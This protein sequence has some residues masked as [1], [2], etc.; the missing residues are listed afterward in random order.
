MNKKYLGIIGATGQVGVGAVKTLLNNYSASLLLGGRKIA[1][2]MEQFGEESETMKYQAV[3]VFNEASIQAFCENCYL[4]IN[5]AGPS[6]LIL[7]R[8]AEACLVTNTTYID[9]SGDKAMKLAI[10]DALAKH[11]N[12]ITCAISGGVYP[13]LTEMFVAYLLRQKWVE[14][15]SCYFAGKGSF[16][17]TGA[18]D[19]ISSLEK[20]EGYGMSYYRN[21]DIKKLT[22]GIGSQK[23][24][25]APFHQVYT[26]PLMNEEFIACIKEYRAANAF[27]YNTFATSKILSDFIMIK[28]M[29][30][31]KTEEE[32]RASAHRLIETYHTQD[33]EHEGFI[34]YVETEENG[35]TQTS[36][37]QSNMNWN[38]GSGVVAACVAMQ[39]Q[40]RNSTNKKGCYFAQSIV[41]VEELMQQLIKT[42]CI[43][44]IGEK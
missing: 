25:P 36:Y 4:V 23:L 3:D 13:G 28:A 37:L 41:D 33:N 10:E 31:Y 32:K 1:K 43:S 39:M 27:F 17:E 15:I 21:G 29:Q 35:K 44:I 16:S 9:V 5:A 24:L 19:I 38:Y 30:L 26:L 2:L 12:P 6:S 7:A 8:V 42:E 11:N 22:S 20:D 34:I 40:E 18:Y 14:R